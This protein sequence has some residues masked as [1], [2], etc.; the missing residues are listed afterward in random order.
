[1]QVVN[2]SSRPEELPLQPLTEPY[3]I[4]S[5]RTALVTQKIKRI[6]NHIASEQITPDS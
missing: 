4:L 1:V 5:H 2:S 3:V 6:E